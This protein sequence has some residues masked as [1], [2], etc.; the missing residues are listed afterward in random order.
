M[1]KEL[2]HSRCV[3]VCVW[4]A[5]NERS[6]I[7]LFPHESRTWFAKIHLFIFYLHH[8][9]L[10]HIVQIMLYIH[11]SANQC[12]K[13]LHSVTR[14]RTQCDTHRC[15]I[16]FDL[17]RHRAMR[18]TEKKRKKKLPKLGRVEN[19]PGNQRACATRFIACC[20]L[21]DC[22]VAIDEITQHK[23]HTYFVYLRYSGFLIAYSFKPQFVLQNKKI[24]DPPIKI[25][26][27]QKQRLIKI[28]KKLFSN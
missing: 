26:Q 28:H 18:R 21:T 19:N 15:L 22:G 11:Y 23:T 16:I 5:P 24:R 3:C 17:L 2:H 13:N 14:W 7:N 4:K 12:S 20:S 6:T 1:R 10:I 9:C 25:R 8:L 27:K